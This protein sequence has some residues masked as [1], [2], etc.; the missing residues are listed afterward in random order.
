[1]TKEEL[2]ALIAGDGFTEEEI[3]MILEKVKQILFEGDN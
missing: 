2:L 3:R 1:M